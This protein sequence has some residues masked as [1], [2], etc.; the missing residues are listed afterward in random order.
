MPIDY[1][2]YPPNW[3]TEIRPR[4]LARAKNRCE[5]CKVRNYD[6][7]YRDKNGKF[8]SFSLLDAALHHKGY[9][10][11]DHELKH[12]DIDKKPLKIVLTLAHLDHGLKDHSDDNLQALCQRC[13]FLLDREQHQRN[14]RKTRN[15]KKGLVDMFKEI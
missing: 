14:A 6:I 7:G 8:Y 3:K 9:D 11:F 2:N 1:K 4:I 10:Y 5:R 15:R 12:I 13:H